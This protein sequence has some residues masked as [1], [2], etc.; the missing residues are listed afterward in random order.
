MQRIKS[1]EDL[2]E[3]IKKR[4]R[5]LSIDKIYS[6]PCEI[7]KTDVINFEM[8]TGHHVYCSLDCLEIL[9]LSALNNNTNSSF[10]D[11]DSMILDK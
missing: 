8:C 5:S 6:L 2:N 7:C 4:K 9:Y 10:S 11:N 1:F 3:L